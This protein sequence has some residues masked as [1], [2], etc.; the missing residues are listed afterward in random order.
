MKT[1]GR[2]MHTNDT[3]I[4]SGA[5]WIHILLSAYVICEFNAPNTQV[6]P[7]YVLSLE[8]TVSTEFLSLTVIAADAV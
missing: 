4:L 2:I 1:H 7:D 6:W 8:C 5:V 3:D